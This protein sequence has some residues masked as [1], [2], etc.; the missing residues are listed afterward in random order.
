MQLRLKQKA[1]ARPYDI[2]EL[3]NIKVP[4]YSDESKIKDTVKN[5]NKPVL[6]SLYQ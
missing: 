5:K 4:T 6:F 1:I 2:E 3:Q